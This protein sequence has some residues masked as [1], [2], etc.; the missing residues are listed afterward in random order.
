MPQ[1]Y[2]FSLNYKIK[3]AFSAKFLHKK[4]RF[5]IDFCLEKLRFPIKNK[6]T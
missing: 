1:S 6:D 5:P 3:T 4:Q 2:T